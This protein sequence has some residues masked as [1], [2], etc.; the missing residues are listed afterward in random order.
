[1]AKTDRV[2]WGPVGDR[3]RLVGRVNGM[4]ATK[5]K[6]GQDVYVVSQHG[7]YSCQGKVTEVAPEGVEVLTAP[8]ILGVSELSRFNYDVDRYL[9]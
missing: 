7:P 1:M 8:R 9:A 6:V 3:D 2:A 5:L 4:D